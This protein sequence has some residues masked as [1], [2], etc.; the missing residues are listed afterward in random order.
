MAT[1]TDTIEKDGRLVHIYDN[2]MERDARTGHIIRRPDGVSFT[3]EKAR[4]ARRK[5]QE[6]TARLLR[7]KITEA[8]NAVMPNP[9]R[10]SAEAFADAGSMLWDQVVL[11]T[12]AYPRDR[13]DMYEMLGKHSEVFPTD[14]KQAEED[15]AAAAKL[16][17][18]G[19]AAGAA[20]NLKQSQLMADILRDV[21]KFQRGEAVP[22]HQIIDGRV[23][24]VKD[25]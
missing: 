17:A 21:L 14:A 15:L 22:R 16:L 10:S 25:E 3:P 13:K 19:A 4:A 7:A 8:H 9:A 1:K 2:G 23:V 5:R 11:N 12:E 18:G 6:K 20:V 24:D